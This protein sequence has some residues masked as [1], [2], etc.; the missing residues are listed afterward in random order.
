M[1]PYLINIISLKK[2][3]MYIYRIKIAFSICNYNH[4]NI[5]SIF[6]LKILM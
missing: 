3:E 2:T 5:L 6:T 4:R 1:M